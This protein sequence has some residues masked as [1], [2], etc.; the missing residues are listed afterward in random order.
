MR[1]YKGKLMVAGSW[2]AGVGVNDCLR[3]AWDVVRSLR[4]SKTGTGLEHVGTNEYVRLK[5]VRQSRQPE[6]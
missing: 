3:S 5:P 4:D 6:E 2:M 1:E